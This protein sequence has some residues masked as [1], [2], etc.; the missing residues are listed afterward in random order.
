M[1]QS[2]PRFPHPIIT[3]ARQLSFCRVLRAPWE[4]FDTTW[5]EVDGFTI[6]SRGLTVAIAG[7]TMLAVC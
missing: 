5:I 6:T 4:D 1:V 3:T 7:Q 2:S